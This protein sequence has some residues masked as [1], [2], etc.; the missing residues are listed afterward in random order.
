MQS[1]SLRPGKKWRR[2]IQDGGGDDDALVKVAVVE[3]KER[4]CYGA[5]VGQIVLFG[6]G[7]VHAARAAW[8]S[9]WS[10]GSD[11][12]CFLSHGTLVARW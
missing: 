1:I 3:A 9:L 2:R 4:P 11:V 7:L 5:H 12:A 8:S 10:V 6:T